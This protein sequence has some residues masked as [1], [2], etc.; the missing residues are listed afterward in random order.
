MK[1]STPGGPQTPN[2]GPRATQ[3]A[4]LA[5]VGIPRSQALACQR[6]PRD[7]PLAF[8]LASA[9]VPVEM[10]VPEV[11]RAGWAE[12][13]TVATNNAR[14]RARPPRHNPRTRDTGHRRI[15]TEY[16]VYGRT[17]QSNMS[18][19]RMSR[20]AGRPAAGDRTEAT[21]NTKDK[22]PPCNSDFASTPQVDQQIW[23]LLQTPSLR[24][25]PSLAD[26]GSM[27]ASKHSRSGVQFEALLY[28]AGIACPGG[29]ADRQPGTG[30]RRRRRRSPRHMR[31]TEPHPIRGDGTDAVHGTC[32]RQNPTPS[33]ATAQ[34]QSTAHAQDKT[35]PHQVQD[36]N[37][38][39]FQ[40]LAHNVQRCVAPD[41]RPASRGRCWLCG[42]A[43]R[44]P[45]SVS[46]T[47]TASPRQLLTGS[48]SL[49]PTASDWCYLRAA[50]GDC[51]RGGQPGVLA[52]N[53]GLESWPGI[54]A[55]NPGRGPR[56]RGLAG[57]APVLHTTLANC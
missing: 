46:R 52:R 9:Y 51:P 21:A 16:S 36:N 6:Q 20:R 35:P 44:V 4:Q 40:I 10:V 27:R 28:S 24:R 23:D 2:P 34:T 30:Q 47:P 39:W 48:D 12:P 15:T 5:P 57:H 32:A 55:R 11:G 25:S 37:Q 8:S 18:W 3:R 13:A 7:P 33:E 17:S 31:K 54:L 43:G 14:R 41:P 49:A 1:R 56:D 45:G 50:H 38:N 53:P 42:S 22:T 19:N 29:L 26:P